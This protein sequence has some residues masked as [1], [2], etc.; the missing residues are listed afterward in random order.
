MSSI[1]FTGD[2]VHDSCWFR[3]YEEGEVTDVT[4]G[5]YYKST[6]Y[7]AS[8]INAREGKLKI[9][10]SNSSKFGKTVV[11]GEDLSV[12]IYNCENDIPNEPNEPNKSNEPN[13]PTPEDSDWSLTEIW[14]DYYMYIIGV[15]ILIAAIIAFLVYRNMGATQVVEN[16][17][18]AFGLV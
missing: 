5:P 9:S 14:E 2:K 1:Y 13:K 10:E 7:S 11:Q 8:E 4:Y 18:A 12:L 16:I 3:V 6:Q 15:I 17:A